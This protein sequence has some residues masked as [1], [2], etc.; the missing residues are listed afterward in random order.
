MIFFLNGS[1]KIKKIQNFKYRKKNSGFVISLER[2]RGVESTI[3]EFFWSDTTVE[4]ISNSQYHISPI[5]ST[6]NY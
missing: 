1:K 3:L 6:N 5:K 4:F 2:S